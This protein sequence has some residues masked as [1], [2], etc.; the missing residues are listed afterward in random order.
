MRWAGGRVAGSSVAGSSGGEGLF[1]LGRGHGTPRAG[2]PHVACAARWSSSLGLG[3]G[4]WGENGRTRWRRL[5]K[6]G[7]LYM[8]TLLAHISP[9]RDAFVL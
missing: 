5:I 4:V 3:K 2:S 9:L 1:A 7:G 8:L 6:D